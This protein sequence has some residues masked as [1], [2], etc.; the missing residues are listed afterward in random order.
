M[1]NAPE[2]PYEVLGVPST[3]SPQEIS[4][5][6][7]RLVRKHHPDLHPADPDNPTE[8]QSSSVTGPLRRVLEA[9]ALLR[10]PAKRE[11]YDRAASR[12]RRERTVGKRPQARSSGAYLRTPESEPYIRDV[13]DEDSMWLG[14]VRFHVA[15][16]RR[17]LR[18]DEQDMFDELLAML[19]RH[20]RR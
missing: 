12:R 7:R 10:D 4:S 19:L 5:A 11:A 15:P 1:A 14:P 17:N 8:R 13:R 9:Y 3:A 16:L 6:Y 18:S 20:F 2:D